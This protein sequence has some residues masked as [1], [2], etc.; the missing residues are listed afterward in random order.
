[1]DTLTFVD[2]VLGGEG[3]DTLRGDD[4]TNTLN[5]GAGD[6]MLEG[7]GDDDAI[8]GGADADLASYES[9]DEK[10][11]VDLKAQLAKQSGG[12]IDTVEGVETYWAEPLG[13]RSR[14]T[15]RRTH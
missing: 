2:N 11:V 1:M 13:T 7:R 8:R 5:G 14:A 10:V 4:S 15:A 9:D 12:V 3:D 6:D